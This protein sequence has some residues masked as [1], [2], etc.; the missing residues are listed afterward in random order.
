M[1]L[2]KS[3]NA[4]QEELWPPERGSS[5]DEGFPGS[6]AHSTPPFGRSILPPIQFL[7]RPN[8][9]T[10]AK[11]AGDRKEARAAAER[12]CLTGAGDFDLETYD[13]LAHPPDDDSEQ[14]VGN[15]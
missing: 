6:R 2:R 4:A 12:A 14:Y 13:E 5:D 9:W 11:S 7:G 3:K 15:A 10:A 8:V 1:R